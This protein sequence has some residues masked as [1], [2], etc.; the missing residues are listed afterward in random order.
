MATVKKILTD[1]QVAEIDHALRELHDALPVFDAAQDCGIEC[2]Q[3]KSE[4]NSM[5]ENLTKMKEYF[6]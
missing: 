6:G 2:S 4:R 3:W 5:V 1:E